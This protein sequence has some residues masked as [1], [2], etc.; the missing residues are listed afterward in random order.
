MGGL[1][2]GRAV[3]C[4]ARGRAGTAAP[5]HRRPPPSGPTPP[6]RRQRPHLGRIERGRQPRFRRDQGAGPRL[7]HRRPPGPP[8]RHLHPGVGQ[9]L[10]DHPIGGVGQ[11]GGGS[12]LTVHRGLADDR[13]DQRAVRRGRQRPPPRPR[14]P[15]SL[16]AQAGHHPPRLHQ[17][18]RD[19]DD[20]LVGHGGDSDGGDHD[21]RSCSVAT[22]RCR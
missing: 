22:S 11:A 6:A 16:D 5:V 2:V 19:V 20:C 13:R 10:A 18:P 21:P 3:H 12:T 14:S 7:R 15:T 8:G 1:E 4:S 9:P 17:R